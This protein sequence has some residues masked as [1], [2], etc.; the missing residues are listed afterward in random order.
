MLFYRSHI[1]QADSDEACTRWIAAMEAGIDAAFNGNQNINDSHNSLDSDTSNKSLSSSNNLSQ[2]PE[3][4][5]SAQILAIPGNDLC[6]DCLAPG[7]CWASINFCITLCIECSGIHRSL[8]VHLSKVRSL[9]L[10]D[11]EPAWVQLMLSLGNRTINKIYE[12]SV[13]EQVQRAVFDSSRDIRESWIKSKYVNKLFIEKIPRRKLSKVQENGIVNEGSSFLES[14]GEDDLADY[15]S[16]ALEDINRALFT[17]VEE[18]D[19]V[20]I[21]TCLGR[22]ASIN[23][24]NEICEGQSCLH[25]C[26]SLNSIVITEFLLLNGA[27]SNA[28]D[29]LGRTPLHCAVLAANIGYVLRSCSSSNSLLTLLALISFYRQVCHLVKRGAELTVLDHQKRDALSIAVER[30]DADIVTLYV[31][32]HMYM[33]QD[34]MENSRK[35]Q[36]HTFSCNLIFRLRLAKLHEEMKNDEQGN[37]SEENFNKVLKD[38]SS[39]AAKKNTSTT[40]PTKVH[41][42]PT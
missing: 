19:I 32:L 12:A 10:D 17:A 35:R 33:Y 23:W 16:Q 8:G 11:W 18:I 42:S 20:A 40:N 15:E 37:T 28:C 36:I 31:P 24:P 7:P 6:C 13:P 26:V 14:S 21:S 25:V 39:L 34:E 22:G 41:L 4:A 27:K 1:L 5:A 38:F 2:W 3:H 30:A 9:K 29:N